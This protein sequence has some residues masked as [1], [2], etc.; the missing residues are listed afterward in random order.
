MTKLHCQKSG[1]GFPLVLVHGYLGGAAQWERQ[2]SSP[3]DGLRVIAPCLPGFGGSAD[4]A[5]AQSI[6]EFAR[7]LLCFLSAQGI[8]QFFL[9]G[10]SM[11]GM[12]AQEMAHQAGHRVVALVLYGTGALGALPGR[13]ESMQA[14]RQRVL[15][16]GVADAAMRIPEKWLSEGKNSPHYALAVSISKKAA[17]PAHLAGLSAME[18][19][20][21]RNALADIACPTQIVWGDQ[22][23]SY[24]REQIDFLCQ[25]IVNSRLKTIPGAS[26]LAHLES[27]EQFDKIVYAFLLP[28]MSSTNTSVQLHD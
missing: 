24:R 23:R 6:D 16:E 8:E 27:P 1:Y 14:S 17:L 5:P 19:W 9:L 11:G 3:P 22:D 12:I 10:H 7:I 15:T 26:H 13:F 28:L 18:A 2:L 4:I 20:D 25:H 21:G